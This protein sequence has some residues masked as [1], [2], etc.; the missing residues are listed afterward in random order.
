[1]GLFF[2]IVGVGL[3]VAVSMR[4]V[5]WDRSRMT[6]EQRREAEETEK[7]MWIW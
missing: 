2:V 7:E 1:M 4:L 5:Y 6:P 3:P